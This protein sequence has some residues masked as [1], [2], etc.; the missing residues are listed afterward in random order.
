MAPGE[1]E[2]SEL[3]RTAVEGR[4][5]FR[6]KAAKGHNQAIAILE[7]HD[8]EQEDLDLCLKQQEQVSP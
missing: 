4:N 6:K 7:K 8:V 1:A 3:D 2:S 5:R